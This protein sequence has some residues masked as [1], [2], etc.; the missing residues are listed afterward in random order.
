M[1]LAED[2]DEPSGLAAQEL[3]VL[4]LTQR[5]LPAMIMSHLALPMSAR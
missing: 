5:C 4:L 2:D 1:M 3:R